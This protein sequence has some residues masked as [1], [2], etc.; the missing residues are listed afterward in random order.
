MKEYY[1][2]Y[3]FNGIYPFALLHSYGVNGKVA[4][5]IGA[6]GEIENAIA[7]LHG[8]KGCAYH[9]RYS[10]R[11][12]HSPMFDIIS[13]DLNEKD[14]IYGGEDKLRRKIIEVDNKYKP[15]VIFVIP[16]TV[17]DVINEDISNVISEVQEDISAKLIMTK[18][19]VFS[20]RDR[21]IAKKQV[22]ENVKNWD[23]INSSNSFETKGCGYTEVLTALVE[24][25]MEK[26][27]VIP[28]SVNIETFAW[29]PGSKRNLLEIEKILNKIGI[30]V[31]IFIPSTSP[32]NI[33]N[34]TRAEL[35]ITRRLR[36]AKI[37]EQKFGT[38]YV[39]FQNFSKYHGLEGIENFYFQ[40]AKELNLEAKAKEVLAIEKENTINKTKDSLEYIKKHKAVLISRA[41]GQIPYMI[42]VYQEDYNIRLKYI[43]VEF[44]EEIYQKAGLS[45]DT[46][47]LMIQ[48]IRTAMKNLNCKAELII[49]PTKQR[50]DEIFKETD[51]ILGTQNTN[52]EGKG[53]FLLNP[54][55]D[56]KPLDFN[57]YI[58]VVNGLALKIKN[59]QVKSSLLIS[60]ID[61]NNMYFP[62]LEDGYCLA[63]REMWSKMW[64]QRG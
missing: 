47:E 26:K 63:S 39:H 35:N 14:I 9:Y 20:H 59:K 30:S 19:E 49:N 16:T 27:D 53:N 64:L 11:R 7:I 15:E 22:N 28:K 23:K 45:K 24:Q 60:K 31:N 42:K 56:R 52:Y 8:P 1:Y 48:N 55:H 21:G 57:S 25:F 33:K 2:D 5:S 44:Y 62:L 3:A 43:C 10:A 17:T 34:A 61:Q 40:I 36:W 50:L 29:G 32:E 12:R 51:F 46:Y 58:E 54:I 18:S 41:I 37:M 4:G 13:T 6:V 38:R